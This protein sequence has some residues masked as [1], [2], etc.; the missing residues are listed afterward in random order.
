M[1][2]T[3]FSSLSEASTWVA[4]SVP[5]ATLAQQLDKPWSITLYALS[6]I[7]SIIGVITKADHSDHSKERNSN[8]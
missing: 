8:G 4:F 1:H 6:A 7:C 5:L 2:K 3:V